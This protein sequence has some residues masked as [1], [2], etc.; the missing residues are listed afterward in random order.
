MNEMDSQKQTN[1]NYNYATDS[2]KSEVKEF[3]KSGSS[4]SFDFDTKKS[5]DEIYRT[6]R[7]QAYMDIIASIDILSATDEEIIEKLREVV[8]EDTLEEFADMSPEE[9]IEELRLCFEEEMTAREMELKDYPDPEILEGVISQCYI[10][11]CDVHAIDKRGNILEHFNKHK[12]MPDNL[13]PGRIMYNRYKDRCSCIE[14]Y[15]NCCRVI[16]RNG[17]VEKIMKEDY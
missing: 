8:D 14:V 15:N 13:A 9:L 11:G 17:S 16:M 6:P 1:R 10:D 7:S 4:F 12:S 5:I 3:A 2:P